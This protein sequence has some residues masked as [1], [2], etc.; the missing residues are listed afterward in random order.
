MQ[1]QTVNA[2]DYV[3]LAM[4][5]AKKAV[6]SGYVALEL[7]DAFQEACLE[8]C[9]A[10]AD[11]DPSRG[12]RFTTFARKYIF[13]RFHNMKIH[14]SAQSRGAGRTHEELHDT[15]TRYDSADDVELSM[16][17]KH[18]LKHAS[19]TDRR[20]FRLRY[21]ENR[22]WHYIGQRI[23]TCHETASRRCRKLLAGILPVHA[24]AA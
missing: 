4:H 11:F 14:A 9:R 23:G 10:A 24:E 18:T 16:D 7:E 5:Y 21:K 17:L 1:P 8:L 19:N 12:V 15:A 3:K 20:I 6:T 2:A 22:S 13:L